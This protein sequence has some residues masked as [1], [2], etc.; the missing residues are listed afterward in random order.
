MKKF[1]FF[2][3]LLGM[4]FLGSCSKEKCA[5]CT[6]LTDNTTKEICADSDGDLA[7][8]IVTELAA[9]WACVPD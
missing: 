3:A 2:V 8:D 7:A 4:V 9:G 5:T 6:N 1:T